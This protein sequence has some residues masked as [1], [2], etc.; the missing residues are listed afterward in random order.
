M[1]YAVSHMSLAH[2][3]GNVTAHVT[4]FV[5]GLYPENYF[6]TVNISSTMAYRY[7]NIFRN[8]NKEF[9]RKR[10]PSL[11][12]RPRINFD[13]N[14]LFMNN[15]LLTTRITDNY[16]DRDF[17]N[18]QPF[19]HDE[20][21][22]QHMKFLL[23]RIKMSFD[24]TLIF[25][26]PMEQ[27]NMFYYTKNV[28]RHERPFVMKTALESNIPKNIVKVI[29]EEAGIPLDST[30]DL[31]EY[32]NSNSLYP[33]TY[34]LKNST[35]ND[36]FFR[37][38]PAEMDTMITNLSMDDGAKK[39][40]VNDAY[41]INFTITTEFFTSGLYYYFTKTERSL[42]EIRMSI[43]ADNSI[44]PI[45]TVDNLFKDIEM[46]LGWKQYAAPLFK[47]TFNGKPDVLD[48]S[49]ILNQSIQAT[50][51][52]H[53]THHMIL[54]PFIKIHVMR[55]NAMLSEENGEYSIDYKTL[56]LTINNT[57]VTSTYR[58]IVLVNA[59]YINKLLTDLNGFD[60]EK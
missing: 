13:D 48:L 36:E 40:F 50:I 35:G 12:I 5:K 10:K 11:I 2:T 42:D 28:V 46:P 24:I 41:A 53:V 29:A 9:I 32:L 33:I 44:I 54:S 31:L 7:F 27:M 43:D 60:K 52:Y 25:E 19:F 15:T 17:S 21:I 34:K 14:D 30:P 26:Q 16:Y 56:K 1:K 4:E 55:D 37:F 47:V 23:N 51:D 8:T 6:K 57:N 18:L 38:Y 58:L 39:G 3:F 45:F 20:K 59:N 22:G 49:Q